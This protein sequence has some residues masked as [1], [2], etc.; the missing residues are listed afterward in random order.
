MAVSG[1]DLRVKRV[2]SKVKSKDLASVMGV[3][4]WTITRIEQREE[5][6]LDLVHQYLAA[7]STCGTVRKAA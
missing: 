3:G 6:D 1:N 7:L 5:V 4:A 2:Q